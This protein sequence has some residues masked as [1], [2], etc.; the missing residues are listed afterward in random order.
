MRKEYLRLSSDVRFRQCLGGLITNCGLGNIGRVPGLAEPAVKAEWWPG[1]RGGGVAGWVRSRSFAVTADAGGVL[2]GS[3][4]GLGRR[5]CWF[6]AT[7]VGPVR[8][9]RVLSNGDGSAVGVDRGVGVLDL[10][11]EDAAG[12]A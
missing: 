1:G 4:A 12:L 2:V 5:A 10:W 7:R 8:V 3:D 11:D 6:S 9:S